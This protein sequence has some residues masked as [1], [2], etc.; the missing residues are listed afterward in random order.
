MD[1]EGDLSTALGI[2]ALTNGTWL[3][4]EF[5]NTATPSSK[6][7]DTLPVAVYEHRKYPRVEHSTALPNGAKVSRI[8]FFFV[9]IRHCFNAC[10]VHQMREN[11]QERK[12]VLG[13]RE[14]CL[15]D[16]TLEA[17]ECLKASWDKGLIRGK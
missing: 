13:T 10:N 9:V 3:S 5:E 1:A 12:E 7:A 15:A 17:T 14:K 11:L 8:Y 6:L 16:D 4:A 2:K